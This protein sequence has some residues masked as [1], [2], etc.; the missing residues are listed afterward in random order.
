MRA[1]G[2]GCRQGVVKMS[3]HLSVSKSAQ[4]ASDALDTASHSCF[5]VFRPCVRKNEG[6]ST[7][8]PANETSIS[9]SDALNGTTTYL[10]T[11][12]KGPCSVCANRIGDERVTAFACSSAA[13]TAARGPSLQQQQ[14]QQRRALGPMGTAMRRRRVRV[15]RQQLKQHKQA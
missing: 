1:R 5:V 11:Q 8:P 10:A 15:V 7:T 6:L 3:P 2:A 4:G 9:P 14:S 12:A 13:P